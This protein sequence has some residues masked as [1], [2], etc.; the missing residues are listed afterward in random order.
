[1]KD[2]DDED[3]GELDRSGKFTTHNI[4]SLEGGRGGGEGE[5]DIKE[6]DELNRTFK[7]IGVVPSAENNNN[8]NNNNS[9]ARSFSV[10]HSS[11]VSRQQQQQQ[12]EDEGGFAAFASQSHTRFGP[13]TTVGR[14]PSLVAGR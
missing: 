1:M 14:R 2:S 5:D 7:S 3:D 13:G 6:L 8:N 9:L 10:D 11:S 12:Q 4:Q